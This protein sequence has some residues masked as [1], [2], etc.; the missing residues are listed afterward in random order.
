MG[1]GSAIPCHQG[2][3]WQIQ[4]FSKTSCSAGT[5][6]SLLQVYDHHWKSMSKNLVKKMTQSATQYLN[7]LIMPMLMQVVL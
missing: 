5:F 4:G 2:L 3:G 1:R 6:W 7:A